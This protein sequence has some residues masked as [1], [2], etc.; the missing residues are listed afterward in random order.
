LRARPS[1]TKGQ[2]IRKLII[3]SVMGPGIKI[4]RTQIA[5]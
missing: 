5:A 2:Y 4:D 1:A 3:S